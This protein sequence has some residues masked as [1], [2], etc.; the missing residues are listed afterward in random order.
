[1][2][3]Y[4]KFF[5][6]LFRRPSLGRFLAL[7][8]LWAGGA[9]SGLVAE[10][11]HV[12]HPLVI[13]LIATGMYPWHFCIYF[14]KETNE[15]RDYILLGIPMFITFCSYLIFFIA[16]TLKKCIISTCLIM[17]VPVYYWGLQIY[18]YLF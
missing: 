3:E 11:P 14:I 5:D 4:Y 9:L 8:S 16:P 13:F 6:S 18:W 10:G 12:L 15:I 2:K 1:M 7:I 17:Y